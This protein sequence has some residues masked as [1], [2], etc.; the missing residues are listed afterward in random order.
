MRR[1]PRK[2]HCRSRGRPRVGRGSALWVLYFDHV[3]DGFELCVGV[4][5]T[6]CV[7]GRPSDKGRSV[8]TRWRCDGR[9]PQAAAAFVSPSRL[10]GKASAPTRSF[11]AALCPGRSAS[12][13]SVGSVSGD[14]PWILGWWSGA[15]RNGLMLSD[16]LMLACRS[17][18]ARS[19]TR[20]PPLAEVALMRWCQALP[21][22]CPAAHQMCVSL[23][24][25]SCVDA[26]A[27]SLHGHRKLP[28][29]ASLR[30]LQPSVRT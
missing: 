14:I 25:R 24:R 28:N 1:R 29:F 8:N 7:C 20:Q 17:Q 23:S 6:S 19:S 3:A 26:L 4:G 12:G 13:I 18:A 11:R 9:V 30:M 15:V 16:S 5:S 22:P 2:R 21:A 10:S 27:S